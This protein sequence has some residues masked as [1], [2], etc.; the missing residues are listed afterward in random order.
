VAALH[1]GVRQALGD[2]GL[3]HARLAQQDGV[4][5]GAARQDLDHPVHLGVVVGM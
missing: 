3:A 5:L 4:V 1:D 2:G